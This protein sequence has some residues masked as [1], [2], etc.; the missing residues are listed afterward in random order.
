MVGFFQKQ[1]KPLDFHD[2]PPLKLRFFRQ[3]LRDL[4]ELNNQVAKIT[5]CNSTLI[6]TPALFVYE[7]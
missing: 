2:V 5:L 1:K 3:T 6:Y 4:H 7:K